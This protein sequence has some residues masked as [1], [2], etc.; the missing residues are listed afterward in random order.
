MKAKTKPGRNKYGV[1]IPRMVGEGIIALLDKMN[2]DDVLWHQAIK[3][4][5]DALMEMHTFN[6]LGPDKSNFS[7]LN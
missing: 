7:M 4:E 6:I 5:I 1:K 2:C 3:K